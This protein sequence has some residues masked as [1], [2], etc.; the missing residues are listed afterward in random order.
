[1]FN[2]GWT[3]REMLLSE[4]A[5]GNFHQAVDL[6]REIGERQEKAQ[7]SGISAKRCIRWGAQDHA[8]IVQRLRAELREL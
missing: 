2:L 1:L 3:Q 4:E 5:I 7:H 6:F 8:A